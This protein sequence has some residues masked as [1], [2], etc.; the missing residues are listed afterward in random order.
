MFAAMHARRSE[1]GGVSNKSTNPIRCSDP[2]EKQ[3]CHLRRSGSPGTS[4]RWRGKGQQSQQIL[5]RKFPHWVPAWN[6]FEDKAE[7]CADIPP[8]IPECPQSSRL[9][10][11]NLWPGWGTQMANSSDIADE[12]RRQAIAAEE[13]AQKSTN[14]NTRQSYE[15]IAVIWRKMAEQA[16]ICDQE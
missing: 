2:F 1:I 11:G 10:I 8:A 16:E 14:P 9:R 15:E 5:K 4:L 3:G 7:V 13:R 6:L 12:C